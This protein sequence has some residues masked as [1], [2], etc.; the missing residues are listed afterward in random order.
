MHPKQVPRNPLN[1]FGAATFSSYDSD[2]R[3]RERSPQPKFSAEGKRSRTLRLNLN[4]KRLQSSFRNS[5]DGALLL[6]SS[7]PEL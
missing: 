3:R 6:A 7:T 1:E 5:L 2:K 4:L